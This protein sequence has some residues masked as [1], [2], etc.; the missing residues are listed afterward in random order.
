MCSRTFIAFLL[1]TVFLALSVPAGSQETDSKP[2]GKSAR[3]ARLRVNSDRWKQL[4]PA[5][6]REIERIYQQL[7]TLPADKKK[8][9]L[10][11]LR[12]MKP[13]DQRTA[14]RDAKNRLAMAPHEREMR[15]KH[16]EILRRSWNDLA[17][18][19]QKRLREMTPEA[20][21]KHLHA[22]FMAQRKRIVDNLP[23]ELRTRVLAMPP[24]RQADFLR[25]HK[26]KVTAERLFDAR[27][28]AKLR[29]LD[30]KELRRMFHPPHT[31]SATPLRKPGF[32]SS[33]SWKKWNALKPY[34]R[35]R[36]LGFVLGKDRKRPPPG[37]GG[38]RPSPEGREGRNAEGR[39]PQDR[40]R[41][42]PAG[43]EEI[44]KRFDRNA[45]GKLDEGEREAARKY[46][47]EREKRPGGQGYPRG[48][49]PQGDG[50]KKAGVRRA[51]NRERDGRPP[52]P[53]GTPGKDTQGRPRGGKRP[54]VA[55]ENRPGGQLPR[56]TGPRPAPK[57]S[58]NRKK[59]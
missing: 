32:L 13:E 16:M 51:P 42:E 46:L 39:K 2:D 31:D 24:A 28:I 37:S 44:L 54:P 15:R 26:A 59:R 23:T 27:E 57:P 38:H 10:D 14:V 58:G 9:L 20:R 40:G 6:R 55:G 17:P 49:S 21:E 41:G 50:E 5:K 22:R 52:H 45:N 48:G 34:E 29:S 19:E 7:R 4:D 18:T 36:V 30:H 56:K 43:R 12:K 35:P 47:R 25:K 53:R 11:K 33:T 8:Q 1:T 3:P